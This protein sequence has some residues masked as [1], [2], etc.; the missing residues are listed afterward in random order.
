[1]IQFEMNTVNKVTMIRRANTIKI[2]T[3]VEY[4]GASIY[5]LEAGELT[6]TLSDR[7]VI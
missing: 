2:Y 4:S 5:M 3:T 6:M 1:M 7:D